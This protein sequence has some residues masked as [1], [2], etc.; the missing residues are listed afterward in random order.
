MQCRGKLEVIS[1]EE[2]ESQ[3]SRVAGSDVNTAV[4]DELQFSLD[5]SEEG[6]SK[7]DEALTRGNK[8]ATDGQPLLRLEPDAKSRFYPVPWKTPIMK[9]RKVQLFIVSVCTDEYVHVQIAPFMYM[10]GLHKLCSF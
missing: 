10:V 4:D 5:E 8:N 1:Q 6:T 7:D 3:K 2:F 9:D